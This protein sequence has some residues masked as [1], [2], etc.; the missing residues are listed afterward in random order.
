[1]NTSIHTMNMIVYYDEF[2][3]CFEQEGRREEERYF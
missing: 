3:G 2:R 1:M